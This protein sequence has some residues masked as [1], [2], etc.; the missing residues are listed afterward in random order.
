MQTEKD[1][2]VI[3]LA[4]LLHKMHGAPCENQAH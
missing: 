2:M 3:H 4:F 1:V